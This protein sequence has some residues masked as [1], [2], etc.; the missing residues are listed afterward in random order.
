MIVFTIWGKPVQ[1]GSTRSFLHR[2]TRK[3]ITL[4]AAKG[5][6][7]WEKEAVAV[8]RTAS[9]GQTFDGPVKVSLDFVLSL[10]QSERAARWHAVRPDLD[11]L[12]RAVL[13][14]LTVAGIVKDDGQV[15]QIEA[16]KIAGQNPSVSVIV[17]RLG[18]LSGWKE[19]EE[20]V[21]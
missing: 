14:V 18:A 3:V 17:D 2:T 4:P 12:T 21:R 16:T 1:K 9:R 20:A 6:R 11:K 15:A 13:D 7:E 10:P 8:A 5:Y 19:I